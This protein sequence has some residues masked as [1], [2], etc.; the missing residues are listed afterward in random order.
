MKSKFFCGRP[1]EA[2]IVLCKLSSHIIFCYCKSKAKQSKAK[3]R[4][5]NSIIQAEMRHATPFIVDVMASSLSVESID[6]ELMP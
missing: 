2:K 5:P 1:N 3:Q 6:N 4:N